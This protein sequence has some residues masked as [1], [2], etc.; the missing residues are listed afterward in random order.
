MFGLITDETV[1]L[2]IH[3]NIFVP[4]QG[5]IALVAAEVL[6]VPEEVLGPGVLGAEDELVAGVAAGNGLLLGVV[7]GAVYSTLVVVI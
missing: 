6:D 4:G 3:R 1:R 5:S 7:S 2:F